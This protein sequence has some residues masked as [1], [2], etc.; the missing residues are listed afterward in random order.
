MRSSLRMGWIGLAAA[1]LVAASCSSGSRNAAPRPMSYAPPPVAYIDQR[2][3]GGY[4]PPLR[5]PPLMRPPP[6]GPTLLSS[7]LGAAFVQG[8]FGAPLGNAPLPAIPF[9]WPFGNAPNAL[10]A[11]FPTPPPRVNQVASGPG[12]GEVNVGGVIIPIDCL[13]PGYG[14]IPWA[15]RAVLPDSIFRL[16]PA[17]AGAAALPQYVDHREEGLEGPVRFQGGVGA[18]TAFSFAAAVDHALAR[19]A[20]RPGFVSAMHVWSRYHKPYMGLAAEGNRRAPLTSEESWPYTREN[21][22]VAC[23][24][25]S[26]AE[27][28]P[29]CDRY[30]SCTCD[31][32]IHESSCGRQVD[33]EWADARPVARVTTVT[34][35]GKNKSSLM[36][37][38]AKGQDIWM[39]MNCDSEV[40][41]SLI[42]HD[43]LPAVIPDFDGNGLRSGHAMLIAGYRLTANGAYFLLHNS[44]GERWG[45]RGY[46]WVH[47]TT[48]LNNLRSAY[49]VDA[50]PIGPSPVPPRNEKPTQCP[51]GLL[52]DSITA[53][54]AP[55]CPDGSARHN[56]TC[57][58]AT[59]CPAGYVN[60][61]GEC[62][63]A[64]PT[65][66]GMDPAS[67]VRYNCA[68]GGCSYVVPFGF[69]GC[70]LP[71]CTVSCPSPRFR[72]TTDTVSMAC[73]E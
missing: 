48:L 58:D 39:A 7:P 20:G 46:A 55:A 30:G 40:F 53:Q 47:E 24:W 65:A 29:S 71:W 14:D 28:K 32:D 60:L 73:S 64:A 27:C 3:P 6:T 37:T 54:C 11:G 68:P 9:P 23:T 50:E 12:C 22:A 72:L 15:A 45:D 2:A 36:E 13:T 8:F 57:P 34:E 62:V 25:V 49:T 43:G 69:G 19:R 44:W 21:E 10:P 52:S 26:K 16:S 56:A 70:F 18:C 63:V 42:T 51:D 41:N 38:L 33:S 31:M 59:Q 67:K 1:S 35:I 66:K 4:M 61:Y 5:P 17:H